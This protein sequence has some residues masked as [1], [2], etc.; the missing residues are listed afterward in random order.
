MDKL[1]TLEVAKLI[2]LW[3]PQGG[4]TNNSPA[5]I[6]I[7]VFFPNYE[8]KYEDCERSQEEKE[9]PKPGTIFLVVAILAFLT[10]KLGKKRPKL[11]K[12]LAA[13]S[14]AEKNNSLQSPPIFREVPL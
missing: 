9:V 6:Y 8:G 14:N 3:R 12:I 5:C 10:I 2:T 11:A 4:Q 13:R 1:I 7:Y